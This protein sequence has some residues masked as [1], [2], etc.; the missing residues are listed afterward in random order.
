MVW[1]NLLLFAAMAS[2]LAFILGRTRRLGPHSLRLSGVAATAAGGLFVAAAVFLAGYS[3]PALVT[4][5]CTL[6]ATIS[7]SCVYLL[8]RDNRG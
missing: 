2:C 6:S 7:L 1:L 8:Q 3:G 4:L 5:L